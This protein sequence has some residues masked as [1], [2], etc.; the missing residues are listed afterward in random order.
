MA[1]YDDKTRHFDNDGRFLFVLQ[2]R[3]SKNLCGFNKMSW[4]EGVYYKISVEWEPMKYTMTGLH[5]RFS[6]GRMMTTV[7][8]LIATV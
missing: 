6:G 4:Y 2:Q 5:K 7:G 8:K 1:G 3:M